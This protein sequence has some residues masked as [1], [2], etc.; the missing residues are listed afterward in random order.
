MLWRKSD[1][2][3]TR[4]K[5]E[6]LIKPQLDRLQGPI[7]QSLSDSGLNREDI[8]KLILVGG[9]TRIPIVRKYFGSYFET[10]P[11]LGIDP[12]GIVATGASVE[13]C[14]LNGEI[15]ELLLL[16]VT[17]LS[18]GVETTGGLFTRLIKRNSAIPL[19]GAGNCAINLLVRDSH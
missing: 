11:E 16:D 7:E 3:L 9:P 19:M 13:A 5:L 17:P 2:A 8:D 4:D 18:L 6:E 10:Q 12:M 15:K 1:I 14:V